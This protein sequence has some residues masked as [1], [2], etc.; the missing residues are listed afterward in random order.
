MSLQTSKALVFYILK[1]IYTIFVYLNF[2]SRQKWLSLGCY[3]QG[4]S[5]SKQYNW[6]HSTTKIHKLKFLPTRTAAFKR[7][8]GISSFAFLY[9]NL[10]HWPLY[11]SAWSLS[12]EVVEWLCTID[13][14][15]VVST[16]PTYLHFLSEY[17]NSSAADVQMHIC[18]SR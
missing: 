2:F 18:V 1:I 11:R 9:Q 7:S 14:T 3:L 10:Q 4:T 13:H 17:P 15:A 5:I 12:W 8:E 6:M 16:C